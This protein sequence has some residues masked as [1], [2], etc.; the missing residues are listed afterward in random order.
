MAPRSSILVR[1]F[2]DNGECVG[3]DPKEI[4]SRTVFSKHC[5]DLQVWRLDVATGGLRAAISGLT[6]LFYFG[7]SVIL[8]TPLRDRMYSY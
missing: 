4:E 5:E 1:A 2:A 3:P 7:S 8:A 6:P